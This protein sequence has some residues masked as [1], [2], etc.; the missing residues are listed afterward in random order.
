MVVELVE[1]GDLFDFIKRFGGVEE[2]VGR[3]LFR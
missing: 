1:G 2:K 3:T